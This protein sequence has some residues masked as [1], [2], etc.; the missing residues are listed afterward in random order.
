M[1]FVSLLPRSSA[2]VRQQAIAADSIRLSFERFT[3]GASHNVR[4]LQVILPCL[5]IIDHFIDVL[6]GIAS[7]HLLFIASPLTLLAWCGGVNFQICWFLHAFGSRMA[8][9]TLY[10]TATTGNYE[11]AKLQISI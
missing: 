4:F 5:F 11:H 8:H 9:E 3:N 2:N 7:R 1:I 6:K 10:Y